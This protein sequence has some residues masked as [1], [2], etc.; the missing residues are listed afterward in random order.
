VWLLASAVAGG[1]CGCWQRVWLLASV[2]AGE[3]GWRMRLANVG[4]EH[5]SLSL[6]LSIRVNTH[7]FAFSGSYQARPR[8]ARASLLSASMLSF[9]AR[10]RN[11][12]KVAILP[13]VFSQDV[14]N[15]CERRI[16]GQCMIFSILLNIPG[17]LV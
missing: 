3:C 9:S 10:L 12:S 7:N 6:K 4:K 15:W 16:D 11:S 5:T 14:E 1:E 2:V 17:I 13:S 8:V